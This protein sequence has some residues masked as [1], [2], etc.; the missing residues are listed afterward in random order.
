MLKGMSVSVRRECGKPTIKSP[1]F[2]RLR[3]TDTLD[4]LFL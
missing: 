4:T 3:L 2:Y 1:Q